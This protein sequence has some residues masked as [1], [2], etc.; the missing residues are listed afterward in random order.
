MTSRVHTARKSIP[1]SVPLSLFSF[2]ALKVN[3]TT[4]NSIKNT[5]LYACSTN[6][7][8]EMEKTPKI[9][10]YVWLCTSTRSSGWYVS[11]F[12]ARQTEKKKNEKNCLCT[13]LV[14]SCCKLI[15]YATILLFLV[16]FESFAQDNLNSFKVHE[17]TFKEICGLLASFTWFI[18][19]VL[20]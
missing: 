8:S 18:V 12:C 11:V 5:N 13:A 6:S 10:I 20:R 7:S 9:E 1:H 16:P 4:I 2:R 15:S 3:S 14:I 19:G 17:F